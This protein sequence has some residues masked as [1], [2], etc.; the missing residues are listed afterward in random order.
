MYYR[1]LDFIFQS[2]WYQVM[3]RDYMELRHN[4]K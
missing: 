1:L 3:L 4:A 2:R